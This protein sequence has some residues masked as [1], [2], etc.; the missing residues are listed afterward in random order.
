MLHFSAHY[1]ANFD[2]IVAAYLKQSK[3]VKPEQ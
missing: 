1:A 2:K 3:S